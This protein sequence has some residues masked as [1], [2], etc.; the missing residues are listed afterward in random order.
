[1]KRNVLFLGIFAVMVVLGCTPPTS[2]PVGSTTDVPLAPTLA[3][4]TGTWVQ[5]LFSASSTSTDA[6]T[7]TMTIAAN[8]AF[9]LQE[10]KVYTPVGGT[11]TP[12]YYGDQGTVRVSGRTVTIAMTS[13]YCD[14]ATQLPATS[15]SGWTPTN[16]VITNPA[17]EVN[18]KLYFD[19][20][21]D[22]A[23]LTAQGSVSGL[24][25]TWLMSTTSTEAGTTSY[26][27]LQFIFAGTTY[28]ENW[29]GGSTAEMSP[30]TL[31]RTSAGSYTTANGVLTLTP[32]TIDTAETSSSYAL[33]GS[34]LVVGA[35]ANSS[36]GAWAKQ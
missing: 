33:Y 17:I 10:V 18:G 27:E 20:T 25:G 14:S 11:A 7:N 4:A 12:I 8:G 5:S 26:S 9:V 19:T 31:Q 29:Y 6:F 36:A 23:V 1:M 35:G 13:A 2:S 22:S 30:S 3:A 34:Y 21:G 24:T 28:T 32:T 15:S 16:V